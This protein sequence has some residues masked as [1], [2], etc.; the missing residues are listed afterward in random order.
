MNNLDRFI[1]EFN[2]LH[3]E[4]AKRL[5]RNENTEFGK[6]FNELTEK[7][8][9]L[10]PYV[11]SIDTARKLRNILVHEPIRNNFTIAEPSDEIIK[12]LRDVRIKI[13]HPNTVKLFHKDVIILDV[14]NTLIDVLNI[15]KE[16]SITQ[17]PVFENNNFIG[18]LSD[19]GISKWL[20]SVTKQELVDLT[21][22]NLKEVINQDES[23]NSFVIVKSNLPLFEV[24]KSITKKIKEKG[25]SNIVVLIT[26]LEKIKSKD[27]IK[28]IITPWDLPDLFERI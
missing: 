4:I 23:R 16:Y 20:A 14:N 7:N 17:F 12:S 10:K 28:G 15:I 26:P 27:D 22:I 1:I 13:E 11:N 9:S 25:Y 19:N 3:K 24:E 5:N 2:Y 21:E 6:L 8:K 18:M